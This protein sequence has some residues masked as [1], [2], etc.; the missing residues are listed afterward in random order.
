[1]MNFEESEIPKSLLDKEKPRKL[2]RQIKLL[3]VLYSFVLIAIGSCTS[4]IYAPA[5]GSYAGISPFIGAFALLIFIFLIKV[6]LGGSAAG[7]KF[8]AGFGLFALVVMMTFINACSTLTHEPSA[9]AVGSFFVFAMFIIT[10]FVLLGGSLV[11]LGAYITYKTSRKKKSVTI[12]DMPD[13]GYAG[14]D[15]A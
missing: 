12:D 5:A 7:Y 9:G 4:A 1:M 2:S 11:G 3:I 10:V 6:L 14:R 8:F 13:S 15:G